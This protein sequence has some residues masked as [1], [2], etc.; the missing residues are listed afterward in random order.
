[1]VDGSSRLR[2][3]FTVSLPLVAPGLVA[4]GIFASSRRGTSSRSPS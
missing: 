3:F 1:M 2:A 4:T